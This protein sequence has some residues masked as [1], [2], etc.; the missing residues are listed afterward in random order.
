[1]SGTRPPGLSRRAFA[2]LGRA[3]VRWRHL[4][5][6]GAV[7][8]SLR[9]EIILRVSAVSS[10]VVCSVVHERWARS[11]GLSSG[12][13]RAARAGTGSERARAALRYAAVRAAGVEADDP[14]AV[15]AFE[16]GFTRDE[17]EAIRALVDLFVFLNRAN[18]TWE[19]W[20]P[21]AAARRRRLGLR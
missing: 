3:L 6:P 17:R 1:M 13:I 11:I 15:A 7:E 12:E 2:S 5:R 14:A 16:R 8:P 10:C 9:E 18:N 20:L 21:G 4:I 19:G